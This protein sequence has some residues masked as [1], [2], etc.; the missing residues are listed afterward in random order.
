M[1]DPLANLSD[2]S[3][4]DK[5]VAVLAI[6]P[7]EEDHA[8]LRAIIGRTN[9]K[10]FEVHDCHDAMIYLLKN[11]VGVLICE[12]ELP[13]GDWKTLLDSLSA[14]PFQPLVVVSSRDADATLWAEVLNR[15][16]Y[17]VLAK[18]FD[19]IEFT[20]IISLAWLHWREKA[21]R[22]LRD[23]SAREAPGFHVLPNF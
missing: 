1:G 4:A 14:L 15:G 3:L 22:G 13:D 9:W 12:R 10:I 20:R 11:R 17:D 5:V 6:S 7:H 19:R 8:C 2:V 21:T 16:A 23:A 18:P